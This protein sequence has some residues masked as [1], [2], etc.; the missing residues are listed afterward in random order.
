MPQGRKYILPLKLEDK[1]IGLNIK[2][3][4]TCRLAGEL[5]RLTGESK[6]GAIT[7]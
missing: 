5:V 4:E 2:N 6:T 3:E 7:P 1:A